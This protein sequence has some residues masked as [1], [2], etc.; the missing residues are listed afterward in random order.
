MPISRVNF[1]NV[2]IPP[3]TDSGGGGGGSAGAWNNL[4]PTDLTVDKGSYSTFNV[5]ASSETDF[6]INVQIGA[7]TGTAV[8]QFPINTAA[9]VYFDTGIS[10]NSIANG[11]QR[12]AC[13][14][15]M[16]EYFNMG[17][18][19]PIITDSTYRA[20]ICP[21]FIADTPPFT[22]GE[23]GVF[24]GSGFFGGI[25]VPGS[26][27]VRRLANT[28]TTQ[29]QGVFWNAGNDTLVAS[30]NEATLG[31]KYVAGS[32]PAF[33]LFRYDSLGFWNNA[34][35]HQPLL[36]FNNSQYYSGD[37]VLGTNNIVLGA[38]FHVNSG[39][40]ATVIKTWDINIKW[41]QLLSGA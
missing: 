29:Q 32:E 15:L 41:R 16:I 19:N 5:T 8:N 4:L 33:I 9:V 24:G 6:N 35:V 39:T 26:Q 40:D 18:S 12:T 31:Q 22:S 30:F 17:P 28:A 27:F 34:G 38:A 10:A 2:A 3:A 37:L 23:K 11:D 21:F 36:N 13:V 20:S 1:Q 25:N 14:Q 7:D